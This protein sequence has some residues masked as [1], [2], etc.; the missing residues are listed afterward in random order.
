VL[1]TLGGV[2][3]P[4]SVEVPANVVVRG[5]IPHEAVLPHVAAVV[6]HGGMSTVATA[7]AAGVP[8][9]CVPQ[10]R[11]QPLNAMRVV[12]VRAGRTV[13]PDAPPGELAT[14]VQTVLADTQYRSAAQAFAS[15]TAELGNGRKA[16]EMV[17]AL[18]TTPVAPP[19]TTQPTD[20]AAAM[21]ETAP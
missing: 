7:L 5:N 21:D 2:L 15:R 8:L 9:V 11:D 19:P 4:E 10:G 12:E 14:A 13:A 17:E 20:V 16:T 6:T 18:V 1:L 3:A